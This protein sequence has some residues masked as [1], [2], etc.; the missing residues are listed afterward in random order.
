VRGVVGRGRFGRREPG[1]RRGREA[2]H[3]PVGPPPGVGVGRASMRRAAQSTPPPGSPAAKF[4]R[5]RPRR[6]GSLLVSLIAAALPTSFD[7]LVG[8]RMPCGL[9]LSLERQLVRE[10]RGLKRK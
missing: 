4:R 5:P 9:R 7:W 1:Q 2:R 6:G 3:L 8:R 10:F